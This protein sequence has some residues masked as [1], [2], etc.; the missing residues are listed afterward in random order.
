LADFLHAFSQ[1]EA[2]ERVDAQAG[3]NLDAIVQLGEIRRKNRYVASAEPTKAAG[4]ATPQWAV[5]GCPGHTGQGSAAAWSQTVKTKSSRGLSGRANS[6]QLL[7]RSPEVSKFNSPNS[8]SAIGCTSPF[9]WLPALKPRNLSLPQRPIEHSA[10]ML[11][12]ELP[13]HRNKTLY[14]R[15]VIA[16]A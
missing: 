15:G 5:I 16:I 14:S 13:V 2:V 6:S 7:L 3:E 9:G 1:R 4:S 12:A 11:R 10:M 8:L